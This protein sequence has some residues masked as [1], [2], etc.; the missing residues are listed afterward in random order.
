[1][2]VAKKAREKERERETMSVAVQQSLSQYVAE[3]ASAC[4]GWSRVTVCAAE[5]AAVTT[6]YP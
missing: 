4:G 2:I 3:T 5:A 1:M 6:A